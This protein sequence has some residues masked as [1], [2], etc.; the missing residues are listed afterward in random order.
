MADV[1]SGSL[2]EAKERILSM[3]MAEATND[4]AEATEEPAQEA[5]QE[6]VEEASA[7]AEVVETP[8]ETVEAPETEASDSGN[9]PATE[10]P[11][12]AQGYVERF[13]ELADHLDV[14]SEFLYNLKVGTGRDG[15]ELTIGQLKDHYHD[16]VDY[17]VERK[18]LAE[19]R[20]AFEADRQQSLA[21]AGSQLNIAN[22]LLEGLEADLSQDM[23]NINWAELRENDPA[24]FAA[25]QLDFSRRQE[26]LN[27]KRGSLMEKA[28][29]L[30]QEATEA[31]QG[32]IQEYKTEQFKQLL[33]RVPEWRDPTVRQ[34]DEKNLVSHLLMVGYSDNDVKLATEMGFDHRLMVM[35]RESM[36]YRQGQSKAE[37][38]VKKVRA[39]PKKAKPAAPVVED[40]ADKRVK[41]ARA[42]LKKEGSVDALKR[43]L[44]AG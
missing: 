15:A 26:A 8:S 22:E 10:E 29:E 27:Q 24:E 6:V 11:G 14:D 16:Q 25:L 2:D 7:E 34:T 40:V 38:V 43:L 13:D 42:R 3:G 1:V 21:Q 12:E 5:A 31:Q 41:D 19:E 39:L 17:A 36:L 32:Q 37:S 44:L 4:V 20:K 35:A 18:S 28:T 23:A 9:K 30:Q 33:E